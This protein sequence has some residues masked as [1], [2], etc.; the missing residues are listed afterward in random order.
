LSA[1]DTILL[2][3]RNNSVIRIIHIYSHNNGEII[4]IFKSQTSFIFGNAQLCRNIYEDNFGFP[5][6]T[7]LH[8]KY[9]IDISESKVLDTFSELKPNEIQIDEIFE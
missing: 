7:I 9:S 5:I 4:E 8:K 2:K 6:S 3:F 1:K